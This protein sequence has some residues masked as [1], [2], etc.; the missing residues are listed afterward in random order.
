MKTLT[1]TIA[2]LLWPV[3]SANAEKWRAVA[4][5]VA[6]ALLL[7]LSAKIKIPF[8]PVP[9]TLQTMVVLLVG[10][11]F[12]A[13]LGVATIMLYL[14]AGALGMPVFAGTP[15]KGIGLAYMLGPTGGYLLGFALAAMVCGTLVR[16][17]WAQRAVSV[18]AVMLIGNTLIYAC[19]LVWL[20]SVIGWDKPIFAL[21]MFPFLLG[22]AAK[23]IFAATALPALR[24]A[25]N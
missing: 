12:G 13:K 18:V 19:G 5:A 25:L 7:T 17:G 2:E 6:G 3:H 10:I 11:C 21:G 23:I 8:H 20:G 16:L 1:P 24:K 4:L 15:E 14:S 22:D 9:Q